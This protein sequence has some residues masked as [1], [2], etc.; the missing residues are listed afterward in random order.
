MT[1][2]HWPSTKAL[3]VYNALL[4]A[5]RALSPVEIGNLLRE[6]W[7]SAVDAEYVATG[8]SFL[9]ERGFVRRV[10]SVLVVTRRGEQLK[11][12]KKD[13]ELVY[14]RTGGARMGDPVGLY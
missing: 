12:A 2:D 3:S 10:E 1:K 13:A 9:I 6:H 8:E 7:D 11:R 4:I 14:M 5:D